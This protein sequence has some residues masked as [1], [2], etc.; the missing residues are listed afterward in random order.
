MSQE[1]EEYEVGIPLNDLTPEET[2]PDPDPDRNEDEEAMSN[3]A[4]LPSLF[5]EEELAEVGLKASPF[6]EGAD[7]PDM[8]DSPQPEP[9][10]EP[11]EE[12]LATDSVLEET[13]EAP[14]PE[15]NGVEAESE[16]LIA[17]PSLNDTPAPDEEN[18][19]LEQD[20]E[21]VPDD[22]VV[23]TDL[24]LQLDA[25]MG[26]LTALKEEFAGKLKYDTHK[27]EI[28]DKLHQELQEYKQDIVKKHILSIVLDVV[29][30]ASGLRI[31]DLW[32]FHS[33]IQSSFSDI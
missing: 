9:E 25:I 29:K 18:I 22:L 17:E 8:G 11:S 27:D 32:R 20:S 16:G 28:I 2:P 13:P 30:V 3:G 24:H 10:S 14:L 19:D 23:P 7:H 31:S 21:Y 12:D 15:L 33:E 26:Q 6:E 5:D 1:K 4:G